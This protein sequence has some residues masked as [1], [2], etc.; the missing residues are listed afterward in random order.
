MKVLADKKGLEYIVSG[1]RLDVWIKGDKLWL[2]QILFNLI[3]NATKYT[4]KGRV[5]VIST[6][7]ENLDTVSL[8]VQVRD[9]GPGITKGIQRVLFQPYEKGWKKGSDK[10][11]GLG[12]PITKKLIEYQGG[13]LLFSTEELKGSEFIFTIPYKKGREVKISDTGLKQPDLTH[14]NVLLADDDVLSLRLINTLFKKWN[15]TVITSNDCDDILKK[16]NE[17]EFKIIVLDWNLKDQSAQGILDYLEK[18]N[19]QYPVIIHSAENNIIEK[20]A[21]KNLHIYVLPKPIDP[22][23]LIT[24]LHENYYP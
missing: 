6:T 17:N 23:K 1:N 11:T 7:A 3:G 16:L 9:S 13:T 12:L 8:Q 22:D 15:A 5:E 21:S 10:G 14:T 2:K 4:G 19:Y 18:I 24:I 20:V